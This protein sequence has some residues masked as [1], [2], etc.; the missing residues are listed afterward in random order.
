MNSPIPNYCSQCGSAL[1]TRSI[2]GHERAYCPTCDQPRYRNAKPCAGV[3]V[4][5]GDYALLVKRTNPPAVGSWS[6]PAG[7]LEVDEPPAEGAA[8][9]LTEETG[10]SVRKDALE[11]FDTNLVAREEGA[12]VLVIIYRTAE[13]ATTG[14][15]TAGSDAAAA[16]FWDIDE[17]RSQDESLEPGYEPIL[18][19]ALSQN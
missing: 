7:F 18:R 4:T 6:I 17:L 16:Q 14:T 8:R 9:E 1:E 13:S 10:L 5:R 3:I 12:P 15:V 19:R 2:E 11:L